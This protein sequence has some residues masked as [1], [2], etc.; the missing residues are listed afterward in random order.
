MSTDP[1]PLRP[2]RV[3]NSTGAPTVSGALRELSR[4]LILSPNET[5]RPGPAAA[6]SDTLHSTPESALSSRE[7]ISPAR[8]DVG[9]AH[10][11]PFN[12]SWP[13]ASTV[14]EEED[15][16]RT[17]AYVQHAAE[18]NSHVNE[19]QLASDQPAPAPESP[20]HGAAD[21]SASCNSPAQHLRAHTAGS[22][23]PARDTVT[24]R[25]S[26][27]FESL[28]EERCL[29]EK[30]DLLA[31]MAVTGGPAGRVAGLAMHMPGAHQLLLPAN[32]ASKAHGSN[33]FDVVAHATGFSRPS[34]SSLVNTA[35]KLHGQ[36]GAIHSTWAGEQSCKQTRSCPRNKANDA[37]SDLGMAP[38]SPRMSD[39]H[40]LLQRIL[41]TEATAPRNAASPASGASAC[42]GAGPLQDPYVATL[43]VN[44]PCPPY[45]VCPASA[46]RRVPTQACVIAP[47]QV[48]RRRPDMCSTYQDPSSRMLSL[49]V[50]GLGVVEAP[51]RVNAAQ[52]L[53]HALL[54]DN[55]D[56]LTAKLL[57][58]ADANAVVF[59]GLTLLAA[60]AALGRS[61]HVDAL[62]AAGADVTRC[63][64]RP[65]SLVPFYCMLHAARACRFGL[66]SV[67]GHL[68]FCCW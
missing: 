22:A 7:S 33:Y 13:W 68:S 51:G 1:R 46:Q 23:P 62:I 17:L 31:H 29:H 57:A 63:S 44:P 12:G 55:V 66:L 59:D 6:A 40:I 27:Y 35:N 52:G 61:N 60:A 30:L 34:L 50:S 32:E 48:R 24:A 5:P 54:S 16:A 39:E 45:N 43:M 53:E 25:S 20:M 8:S 36:A 3:S 65:R 56:A 58:G 42:V 41:I 28:D 14:E 64:S 15:K 4:E 47:P 18:P 38:R 37:V 21:A 11:A 9:S 10:D 19:S 49:I 2:S 26:T 67:T